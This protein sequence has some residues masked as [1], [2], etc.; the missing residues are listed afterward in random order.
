MF[1]KGWTKIIILLF[2]VMLVPL[3]LDSFVIDIIEGTGPKSGSSLGGVGMKAAVGTA[4]EDATKAKAALE[5][6]KA[7]SK[8]GTAAPS[9]DANEEAEEDSDLAELFT[10]NNNNGLDYAYAYALEPF[11]E[12][13]AT[14]AKA[15]PATAT[16]AKAAPAPAPKKKPVCKIIARL[17]KNKNN[18]AKLTKNIGKLTKWSDKNCK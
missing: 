13:A 10:V 9:A 7:N 15:A 14:K 5:A 3:L 8:A 2:L 16:K 11:F 4:A 6:K 17:D 12:G 1:S 18:S